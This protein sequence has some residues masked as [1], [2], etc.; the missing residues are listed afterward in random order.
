VAGS[1]PLAVTPAEAGVLETGGSTRRLWDRLLVIAHGG[2]T[3]RGAESPEE[4]AAVQRFRRS[5]VLHAELLGMILEIAPLTPARIGEIL[6]RMDQVVEL[7]ADLFSAQAEDAR[8]AGEVYLRMKSAIH[9]SIAGAPPDQPLGPDVT[10][11]V[12]MFEDP[13]SWTRCARCTA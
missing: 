3:A 7:F 4:H 6:C 2:S 10:R 1:L 12:N 8:R 5:N 13:R 9:D 11:L